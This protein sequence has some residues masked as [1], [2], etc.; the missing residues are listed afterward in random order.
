MEYVNRV[1]KIG[2]SGY[3]KNDMEGSEK[4]KNKSRLTAIILSLIIILSILFSVIYITGNINHE[5]S[6]NNCNVCH[7]IEICEQV[8][9]QIGLS[10]FYVIKILP[11]ITI[12]GL[13]YCCLNRF[14]THI[15]LITLKVQLTC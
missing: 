10:F 12:I 14:L 4:M 2:S 6:G 15:T 11:V 3:I 13:L 7:N 1:E 8:I 9:N 5:C